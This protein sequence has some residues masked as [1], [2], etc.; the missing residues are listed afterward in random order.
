MTTRYSNNGINKISDVEIFK[1][2]V[3]VKNSKKEI[4]HIR[5]D[6]CPGNGA[7][8]IMRFFLKNVVHTI[9]KPFIMI[10]TGEDITIPTQVDSR[11]KTKE[12]RSLIKEFYDS[13]VTHPLLIH[14]YIENRDATHPKTSSLP[15]GLNPREFQGNNMNAIG[16][17]MNNIPLVQGR[18]LKTICIHRSKPGDRAKI[19]SIKHNW[20]S[21]LICGNNKYKHDS[22]YKLL[23]TYPFIICAHGGGIDPSPKVWEALCVGCIPIIKHSSL[24]DVYSQF[25]VVFVDSFN[26]STITAEK[27]QKWMEEY[28]KYFDLPE[29]KKEWSHKLYIGYWKNEIMNRLQN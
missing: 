8:R 25:P 27:L 13:I 28:S 11:W 4:Y 16:K 5:F 1:G 26:K 2:R 29:L 22:W 15:L 17:F 7:F 12:H 14:F 9:D 23:Q 24:D 20:K 21:L 3:H 18:P 10:S 19:D 6:H